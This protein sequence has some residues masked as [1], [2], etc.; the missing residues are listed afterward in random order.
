MKQ[1]RKNKPIFIGIIFV[2]LLSIVIGV[3]QVQINS[4]NQKHNSELLNQSKEYSSKLVSQAKEYDSKLESQSKEYD[5]RFSNYKIEI[6]SIKIENNSL[7]ENN[8]K[9]KKEVASLKKQT[10]TTTTTTKPTSTALYSASKFRNAGIVYYNN[11]RWT[12]YSERVLPGNG[13]NIPNRHI[14]ASGYVCDKNNNIC[15]AASS[16]SKGTVVDT[17]FGKKGKV[18]DDG[19]AAGTLD[20]YVSW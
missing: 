14:D 13:L 9:L 4:L 15:L 3:N 11:Y 7:V 17:P 5:S 10:T 19:C 6:N 1:N 8:S 20:V 18:Y 16:L 2:I 12:W